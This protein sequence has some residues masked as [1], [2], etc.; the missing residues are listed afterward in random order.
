MDIGHWTIVYERQLTFVVGGMAFDQGGL[1]LPF[2]IAFCLLA[3][4]TLFGSFFL[5]YIDPTPPLHPETTAEESI[6]I[7]EKQSR[8]F[9]YP[10]KIFIPR[11]KVLENGRKVRDWN[12]TFLGMGAFVSVLATGYV[13]MGLQLVA[14]NVFGFKPGPSGLMLVSRYHPLTSER[15]TDRGLV[16][17]SGNEGILPHHPIPSN[18]QPRSSLPVKSHHQPHHSII[19]I[20]TTTPDHNFPSLAI[21]NNGRTIQ[22]PPTP[23]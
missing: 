6:T 17:E 22:P 19:I 15:Y 5:P 8:S 3:F 2:Q 12:L 4:T 21:P 9:L 1:L 13:G 23:S 18:H 20:I 14:T 7:K 10:L 16:F 11:T